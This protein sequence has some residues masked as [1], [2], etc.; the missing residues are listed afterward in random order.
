[1]QLE[2][3]K[4]KNLSI[5]VIKLSK[6]L[7]EEINEHN[8]TIYSK[9]LSEAIAEQQARYDRQMKYLRGGSYGKENKT[10]RF[11]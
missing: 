11:Y 7:N 6:L 10:R 5:W 8:R 3:M 9:W 4:E 2:K 1:M